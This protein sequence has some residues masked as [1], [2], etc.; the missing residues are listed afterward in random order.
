MDIKI[1]RELKFFI[2]RIRWDDF[3]LIQFTGMVSEIFMV[4]MI[5]MF[6]IM[7]NVIAMIIWA[8]IVHS[9][10][11][12]HSNFSYRM[13]KDLCMEPDQRDELI[14]ILL[15]ESKEQN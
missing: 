4:L 3:F 9:M 7:D 12:N 2:G 6:Y 1:F 11:W 13:F 8:F 5:A 14:R 15:N 10:V